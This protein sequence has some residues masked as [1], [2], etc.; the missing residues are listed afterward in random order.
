MN[1]LKNIVIRN[2]ARQN[3]ETAIQQRDR[4][5]CIQHLRKLFLEFLHP[6]GPIS[7]E[8]QELKQ[9]QMLPVFIKAFGD[10]PNLNNLS[11]KFGDVLQFAGHTSKLIVLEVQ[12]RAANKSNSQ[13]SKDIIL[14]LCRNNDESDN[15]GWNLLHTLLILADGELAIIECMVAATLHSI[16][17]KCIKLFFFLPSNFGFNEKFVEVQ[18]TLVPILVKLC[19]HPI[20]AKELVRTD[21]LATLFEAL[22]SSCK[23]EHMIW[24]SGISEVLA[25]ITRHCFT[26]DV[27]N[28]INGNHYFL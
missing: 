12:R 26:N 2:K 25:S 20:T 28:Y 4:G 8:Q 1:F 24:R 11:D 6:I 23:S 3:E 21:D 14:F 16:L 19:N 27:I 17:V 22:T 9:Y 18:K 10:L 13:A 5:L 15:K 7:V